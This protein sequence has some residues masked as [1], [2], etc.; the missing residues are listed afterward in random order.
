ML[1]NATP[2]E[3]SMS[4]YASCDLWSDM[5]DVWPCDPVTLIIVL[6]IEREIIWKE[7]KKENE[8]WKGNKNNIE[9]P[10]FS[11]DT[12]VNCA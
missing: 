11:L 2:L 5:T 4:F 7:K 1:Y 9:F 6:R 12:G 8:K 3:P 10:I